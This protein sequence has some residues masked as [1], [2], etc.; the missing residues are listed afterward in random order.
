MRNPPFSQRHPSAAARFFI[1]LLPPPEV[2]VIAHTIQQQFQ[3]QYGS[4]AALRSPPHITLFPPFLWSDPGIQPLS[5]ALSQ[6]ALSQIAPQIHL[7]GFGAFPPRVIYIQVEPTASLIG[8][9]AALVS[10]L[11]Q[12]LALVQTQRHRFTPHLTVAFRDLKSEAF[13]QSWSEFQHRPLEATFTVPVLTLLRHDGQRWQIFQA[14][15]FTELG[16]GS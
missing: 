1:A 10:D 16:G 9:Q 3:E 5:T 14:F 7:S 2:Q 6:F 8:L 11:G 12:T 13:Y 15:P 4:R